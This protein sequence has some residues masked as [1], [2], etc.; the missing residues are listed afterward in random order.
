MTDIYTT[1]QLAALLECETT[2]V[3]EKARRRELPGLKFGRGW[4]FP[5]E[6]LLKRLNET[7]LAALEAPK[8]PAAPEPQAAKKKAGKRPLPTLLPVLE[9]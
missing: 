4:I 9:G 5:R 7:A 3:E 8:A 2:T 6:A 1:E